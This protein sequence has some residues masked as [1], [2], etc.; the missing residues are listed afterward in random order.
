MRTGL[1]FRPLPGV[2]RMDARLSVPAL[3]AIPPAHNWL[4]ELP[5]NGD[6]LGNDVHSDCVQA[7]ELNTI[8]IRRAVTFGDVRRPTQA[9]ALALYSRQSGY[10]PAVPGSDTGTISSDADADWATRGIESDPQT[11]DIVS[12]VSI[13]PANMAHVRT[14]IWL[15]GPVQLD[16]ALPAAL[17]GDPFAPWALPP[18]GI[19]ALGWKPGSLGGHRVCLGAYDEVGFTA[20][21]WGWDI[22][23]SEGFVG[24]YA[25]QIVATVSR[26]WL[27]S[28]GLSPAGLDWAAL[29]ADLAGIA[30]A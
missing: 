5:A 1:I 12:W 28:R 7:A 14:A 27:D 6:P 23:V 4:Q 21:S 9:Q 2:A 22:S 25:L 15:F 29:E 11:L 10:D 26:S 18:A 19:N 17:Q 20:R 30:S 24:A 8:Y 3:S 16:L 13:D